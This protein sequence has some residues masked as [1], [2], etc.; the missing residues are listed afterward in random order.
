MLAQHPD[1]AQVHNNLATLYVKKGEYQKA[2]HAYRNAVH[3]APDYLDAHFNL[4]S[5]LLRL[6]EWE[7]AVKQF[8]NVITLNPNNEKAHVQLG[9]IFLQQNDL[10][11]AK[12]HYLNAL[13]LQPEQL[14]VLNNLGVIAIKQDQAQQ[15]IDYFTQVLALDD[16][17]LDARSNIAAL[18]IHNDRY[19]NALRHYRIL[20]KA[21]PDNLEAHYNAGVASM[22]LGEL[23]QALEHFETVLVAQP[24]N[25]DTHTNIG[26]I[27][28]RLES[29]DKAIEHFKQVMAIDPTNTSVKHMLSAL[30][31]EE[32]SDHAP[33]DYVTNL[34]D[35]YAL[36]YDN[37]LL[38]ALHYQVPQ[39]LVTA[40]KDVTGEIQAQW[41]V[42]DIGCG[43]GLS[44]QALK[45]YAKR[46]VGID[47]SEK[48]LAMAK[49][50]KCYDQLEATDINHFLHQNK[51]AFDLIIAADVFGYIG[52]L[53]QT[54]TN[55]EQALT[56][57][58][59]LIFS[60]EQTKAARFTLQAS[61]RYAHAKQY[62]EDLAKQHHF[63]IAYCQTATLRQ[64]HDQPVQ[65]Q[66]W[67][68]CLTRRGLPSAVIAT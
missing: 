61:G 68:L 62:I 63:E 39:L 1:N 8:H 22:A 48:M 60:T 52:E 26:A 7:A 37:H 16:G 15:A 5:L 36:Y 59:Y 17:H 38:K 2:L 18:F 53:T 9:N 4:G 50:K 66:I 13:S 20:F 41:S 42:C 29:P 11:K 64:H 21:N 56:P 32:Q 3:N 35:H 46:L 40:L 47:L 27:Y 51:Q 19:E 25:I 55:C 57:S 44:G 23:K 10:P 24:D 31:G 30:T 54:F 28:M 45:L 34:F 6:R 12:Q 49:K 65:G 43:T 58:G 67:V 33:A 14:E